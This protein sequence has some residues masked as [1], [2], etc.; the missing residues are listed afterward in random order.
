MMD[1]RPD[2]TYTQSSAA[3]YDWME[4]L[5]PEV[6]KRISDRVRDGRWEIVGGMW[7][8][9]DCNIPSGESFVRQG[10]YAQRYFKEKFGVPRQPGMVAAAT[11]ELLGSV[12][13]TVIALPRKSR[14]RLPLP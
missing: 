3:Y 8:E 9:P 13:R 7:I 14:S 1:A 2:F 11:A 5:Y 10:L 4:R 6:F 12:L